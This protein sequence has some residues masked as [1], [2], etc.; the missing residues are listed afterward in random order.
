MERSRPRSLVVGS[1]VRS[2]VR[3]PGR[4]LAVGPMP[5]PGRPVVPGRL[6]VLAE[7]VPGQP[8]VL[9]GE[10]VPTASRLFG[11]VRRFWG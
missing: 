2:R 4:V 10:A 11:V 7:T 5:V 9:P 1:L 6:P 3:Q 8:P